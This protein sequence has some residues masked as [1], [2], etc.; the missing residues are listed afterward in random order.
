MSASPLGLQLGLVLP[1]CPS[2]GELRAV[3]TE[4]DA[5]GWHSLWVTDRTI[6]GMPWLDA[7]TVLGSLAVVTDRVHIGTS[8]LVLPRRNPV[9]V[10]HS[11]ASVDHLSGGRLIAGF[12]VGNPAVSTPEFEIAGVDTTQRGRLADDY[13]TLVRRLWTE[14]DV[15]YDGAGWAC[16]GTTL[17]PKPQGH[18]QIWVGGSTAAARR[19][20]GRV[21]DGWLAVASS[22]Q[23]FPAE[24][25]EVEHAA[26]A[27]GRDPRELIP[28]TYLFAAVDEDGKSSRLL[29]D[30]VLR[31]FLGAPLDAVADTCVFGTPEQWLDRLA[32]WQAA[33]ARHVNVALF[34]SQLEH[35]VHLLSEQVVPHLSEE[36]LPAAEPSRS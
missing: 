22:P 32:A 29:L 30:G 5:T 14:D 15:E 10:A 21:G 13:L 2:A 16:T 19:R 8:V 26:T 6:A 34:S 3:A 33:G 12:G 9:H 20:A 31:Q 27:A 24:W 7:L 36:R 35:D 11:L 18:V 25:G 17:A 28:A 1:P 4:V 23:R